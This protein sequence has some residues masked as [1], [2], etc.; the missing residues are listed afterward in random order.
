MCRKTNWQG[1]QPVWL[2]RELLLGLRKKTRVYHYWKQGQVTQEEYRGLVRSC[3][4]EIR[5]AKAQLTQA[6]HCC[7]G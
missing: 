3:R 6:G 2:N 7:K 1:R 5:K 4:Q